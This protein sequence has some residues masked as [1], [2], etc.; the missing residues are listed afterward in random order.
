MPGSG[1]NLPGEAAAGL[2]DWLWGPLGQLPLRQAVGMHVANEL[3][4]G[5]HILLGSL[6]TVGAGLV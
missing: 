2:G 4:H 6:G 1:L 5:P 3:Y